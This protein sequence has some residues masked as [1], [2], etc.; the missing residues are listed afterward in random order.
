MPGSAQP[1][2]DVRAAPRACGLR[3]SAAGSRRGPPPPGTGRV[4]PPR[5]TRSSRP[6]LPLLGTRQR[7]RRIVVRRSCGDP[8]SALLA[9]GPPPPLLVE[10]EL[11]VGARHGPAG[12][13]ARPQSRALTGLPRLA[14]PRP[15][16]PQLLRGRRPL[17]VEHG[18]CRD[19]AVPPGTDRRTQI[20]GRTAG[21]RGQPGPDPRIRQGVRGH[22]HRVLL[23]R[24]LHRERLLLVSRGQGVQQHSVGPHRAVGGQHLQRRRV[25]AGRGRGLRVQGRP[26][27][28]RVG[29]RRGSRERRKDPGRRERFPGRDPANLPLRVPGGPALPSVPRPERTGGAAHL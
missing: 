24:Q 27:P 15:G 19:P 21:P 18:E 29:G 13:P 25:D 26:E 2:P 9:V 7:S 4:R 12:P 22:P 14:E 6:P 11:E 3:R 28:R 17:L 10:P 8:P 1:L 20:R 23:R 5:P 16:P